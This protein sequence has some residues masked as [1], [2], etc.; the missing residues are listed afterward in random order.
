MKPTKETMQIEKGGVVQIF[1]L[2]QNQVMLSSGTYP[3]ATIISF[4]KI[5]CSSAGNITVTWEDGLTKE[6]SLNDGEDF[7]IKTAKS[8]T[9]TS[10]IFHIA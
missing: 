10:G 9:I 8:I 2:L 6:I 7:G 3:N 4:S 5:H 1:P